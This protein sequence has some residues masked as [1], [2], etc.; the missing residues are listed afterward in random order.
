MARLTLQI[1][2]MAWANSDE[3]VA[4]QLE[5]ITGVTTVQVDGM[6]RSVYI[7]FDR[8]R[9]DPDHLLAIVRRSGYQVDRSDLDLAETGRGRKTSREAVAT[10]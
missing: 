6:S 4:R 3:L 2:G 9:C 7:E 1:N 8:G 10:L 5:R